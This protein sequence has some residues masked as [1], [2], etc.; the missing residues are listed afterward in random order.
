MWSWLVPF[1]AALSV[2]SVL[3]AAGLLFPAFGERFMPAAVEPN[4]T[5]DE[6]REYWMLQATVF[7][8]I[9]LAMTIALD[10]VLPDDL[11]LPD[12]MLD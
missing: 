5:A 2:C 8:A 6:T 3:H 9:V 1:V 4:E 10:F 12:W 7:V 11:F